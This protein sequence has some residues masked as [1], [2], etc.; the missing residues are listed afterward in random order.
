MVSERHLAKA[1]TEKY[2]RNQVI[3]ESYSVSG[4]DVE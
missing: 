4:N 1:N 2:E 3:K